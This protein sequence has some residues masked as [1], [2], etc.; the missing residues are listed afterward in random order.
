MF[1]FGDPS[2]PKRGMYA[3]LFDKFDTSGE[4]LDDKQKSAL[5]RK[6][7]LSFAMNNLA[8]KG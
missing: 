5:I 3:S 6:G 8:T 4:D 2:A 1:G 7:L